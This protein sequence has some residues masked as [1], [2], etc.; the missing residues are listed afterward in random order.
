MAFELEKWYNKNKNENTLLSYMGKIS[1]KEVNQILD[2]IDDVLSK[3]E[4]KRKVIKKIYNVAIETLQNLY[5]HADISTDKHINTEIP[6]NNIA[7]LL[8]HLKDE[9]YLII[10]GNFIRK[11]NT[12]LLKERIDQLNFLSKEEV[13]SLYRLILNNEEFSNKGGGGLGIID[14]IKRT[15]NNIGYDFYYFNK[16]YIF[17][18]LRIAI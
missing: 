15:G 10:T 8:E 2:N 12:R 9:K 14:L 17:F 6:K 1:E 3:K 13:K 7:F 5:H 11:T 18:S 4:E 16:D